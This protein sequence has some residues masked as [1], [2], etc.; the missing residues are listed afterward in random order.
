MTGDK[1]AF[2]T[3]VLDRKREALTRKGEPVEIGHRSYVLLRTLFDA[4]GE[5]VGKQALMD[6]VWPGMIV[7]ESNLTVQI[8]ALRKAL[9]RDGTNLLITVPRIG[10]RLVRPEYGPA[11]PNGAPVGPRR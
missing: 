9:G 7:E 1:D 11:S 5:T 8:A 3:F 2:G 4:S 6:A 10:Y